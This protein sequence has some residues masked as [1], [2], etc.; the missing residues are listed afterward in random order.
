MENHKSTLSSILIFLTFPKTPRLLISFLTLYD[1]KTYPQTPLSSFKPPPATHL[2]FFV[3]F[4][5]RSLSTRPTKSVRDN[6]FVNKSINC[7]PILN[8]FSVFFYC[9]FVV[10]GGEKSSTLDDPQRIY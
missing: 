2:L 3:L 5:P 6:V 8:I 7:L 4:C 9:F 10:G 1:I